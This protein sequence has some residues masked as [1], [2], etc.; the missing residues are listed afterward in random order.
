MIDLPTLSGNFLNWEAFC[1]AYYPVIREAIASFRFVPED[2][3]DD[4][5]NS[6]FADKLMEKNF[7]ENRPE[8]R[9]PFRNW[10]FRAVKNYALDQHRSLKRRNGYEAFVSASE[11]D[12]PD[13][14][15]TSDTPFESDALY[16]LTYLAVALQTARR[17]WESIGEGEKW[18]IFD[19]LVLGPADP[20]KPRPDRQQLRAEFPDRNGQYLDN[21]VTSVKRSVTALLPLLLPSEMSEGKTPEARLQE[22]KEILANGKLS[23]LGWLRWAVPLAPVPTDNS[24]ESLATN[25]LSMNL[26]VD[27]HDPSSRRRP[28]PLF[29]DEQSGPLPAEF[30]ADRLRVAQSVLLATPFAAYLDGNTLEA[31]AIAPRVGRG[32]AALVQP[33]QRLQDLLG[34][35]TQSLSPNERERVVARM[36]QLKNYAKRIHQSAKDGARDNGTAP[37]ADLG[38]LLYTV[39]SSVSLVG[40]NT[41]VDSLP[42]A[43]LQ[44]NISWAIKQPWVDPRFKPALQQA[45]AMLKNSTENKK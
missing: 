23:E 32:A 39:A 19:A 40:A 17:H 29:D 27:D 36:K 28:V 33:R 31:L 18:R 45:L 20:T 34:D 12:A 16:A 15:Q 4:W 25:L 13:P 6:F 38:N 30:E 44:G 8:L 7:L 3:V 5:T 22:W 35:L 1:N 9:G 24:N 14:E 26:V 2:L 37:P 41:R 11:V 21:C 43:T 10:L 42:P